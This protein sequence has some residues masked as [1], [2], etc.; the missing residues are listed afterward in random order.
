MST[1]TFAAPEDAYFEF[2]RADSA[3]DAH[4]WA[5]VMSYPH[6][7]VSA[8]GRIAYYETPAEYA[9]RAS[10]AGREATGWVR[11]RGIDPVRLHESDD[12]VHLAGGWTRYNAADQPILRNRVT[13]VT[14]RIHGSW[15]IQARFGTDSFT[16]GEQIDATAAIGVVE[17][18][19]QDVAAGDLRAA[20]DVFS[21]PLVEVGVGRVDR[22][23]SLAE[24]H[25]RLGAPSQPLDVVGVRS[26]RAAQ[27]GR[28]GVVVAATWA[29]AAG[30]STAAVFLLA[31]RD[32]R[33]RIAGFSKLRP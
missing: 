14:T 4:A 5:A 28:D 15:G 32:D 29:D 13:Y 1:M 18:H 6:V 24:V 33:W 26:V 19:L 22:Y 25:S 20:A 9:A 30:R 12:T 11:S 17:Q 21:L 7:R 31:R 3:K 8:T 27:A 10:W 16:A 23:S 2:F